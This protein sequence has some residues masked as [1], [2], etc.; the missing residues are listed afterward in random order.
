MSSAQKVP[1]CITK[2][3]G[4]LKPLLAVVK[5]CKS[6][7]GVPQGCELDVLIDLLIL[8]RDAKRLP[9]PPDTAERILGNHQGVILAAIREQQEA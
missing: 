4:K 7:L 2:I 8:V 6:D 9:M 3:V 5:D 1:P